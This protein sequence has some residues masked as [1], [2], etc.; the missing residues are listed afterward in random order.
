MCSHFTLSEV[1]SLFGSP[2]QLSKR[3][4]PHAPEHVP[5][6]CLLVAINNKRG[7]FFRIDPHLTFALMHIDG[8]PQLSLNATPLTPKV[9]RSD[10]V[11][12]QPSDSAVV[13]PFADNSSCEVLI[14]A[15]Y[16]RFA[17]LPDDVIVG[18]FCA[19][20]VQSVLSLRLVSA[21]SVR[22]RIPRLNLVI[23]RS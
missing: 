10:S 19:L 21:P 9:G 12:R 4:P 15:E 7:G 13:R 6:P 14:V 18:I 3:T 11:P 5:L 23:F 16:F 22:V 1:A 8:R 20:D 17:D 2:K